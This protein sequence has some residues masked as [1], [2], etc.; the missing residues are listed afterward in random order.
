MTVISEPV[1]VLYHRFCIY[2]CGKLTPVRR[3]ETDLFHVGPVAFQTQFLLTDYENNSADLQFWFGH[4]WSY[5]QIE[6]ATNVSRY[7]N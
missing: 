6:S 1:Y 7:L 4:T 2:Q 5:D 3:S